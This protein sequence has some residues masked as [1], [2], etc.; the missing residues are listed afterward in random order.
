MNEVDA[1]RSQRDTLVKMLTR[2]AEALHKR[3]LHTGGFREC[4]M[5]VCPRCSCCAVLD[6]RDGQAMSHC[7]RCINGK[8]FRDWAGETTCANCGH[9]VQLA[10]LPLPERTRQ[11]EPQ[12]M[13]GR[14]ATKLVR[15]LFTKDAP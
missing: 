11:R 14:K 3:S 8:M 6:P 12:L 10:P 2:T 5:E 4:N 9:S 7:Q 13:N 1:L 15:G